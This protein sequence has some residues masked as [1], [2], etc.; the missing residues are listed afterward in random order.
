VGG[1]HGNTMGG[2]SVFK[3]GGRR[4]SQTQW[5]E[6]ITNTVGEELITNTVGGACHK[7]SGR[8][9]SQD[10][11]TAVINFDCHPVRY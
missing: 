10:I 7:H 9:L 3:L 2:V 6:N 5:E 1:V 4:L 8:S 11:D